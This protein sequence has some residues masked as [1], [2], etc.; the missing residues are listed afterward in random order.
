MSVAVGQVQNLGQEMCGSAF[1]LTNA[2][3]LATR[4]K[5]EHGAKAATTFSPTISFVYSSSR[6][7]LQKP[8]NSFSA[9]KD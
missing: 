9:C 1:S 3:T 6:R 5:G 7:T 4:L 2:R 8:R